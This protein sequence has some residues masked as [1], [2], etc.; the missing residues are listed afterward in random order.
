MPDLK[1]RPTSRRC[2]PVLQTWS[3]VQAGCSEPASPDPP[4]FL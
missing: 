3:A 4:D 2:G 1:V